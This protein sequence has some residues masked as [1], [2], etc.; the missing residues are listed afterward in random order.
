MVSKLAKNKQSNRTEHFNHL[1]EQKEIEL[2]TIVNKNKITVQ[3]NGNI[4]IGSSYI[5]KT[6]LQPGDKIEITLGLK[7]I[8]LKQVEND[9]INENYLTN[10]SYEIHRITIQNFR[11]IA[12]FTCNFPNKLNIIVKQSKNKQNIYSNNTNFID[13]LIIGIDTF[14]IGFDQIEPIHFSN[15]D[16]LYYNNGNC[17]TSNYPVIIGCKG[18]IDNRE[19]EWKRSL[20]KSGVTNS[21]NAKKLIFLTKDMQHKV[22]QGEPILLPLIACY[23]NHS[24]WKIKQYKTIEP[25]RPESRTMS[26]KNWHNA[27]SSYQK[28][29]QWFQIMELISR[30]RN[31][32]LNIFYAFKQALFKLLNFLEFDNIFYD[33]E[34]DSLLLEKNHDIFS[35]KQIEQYQLYCLSVFFDIAY[36]IAVLNPQLE[37]EIIEKTPG[38]V[39]I[40]GMELYLNSSLQLK[41]IDLLN[42]TFPKL[43]FIITTHSSY[44]NKNLEEQWQNKHLIYIN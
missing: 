44:I 19:I 17:F 1:P 7:Y 30:Q 12:I 27:P 23:R 14:F 29:L 9:N 39:I 31:K 11:E 38:I 18:I 26:Y 35:L 28:I 37:K 10:K 5:S 15:Q 24:I 4:V 8:H 41:F 22:R 2:D 32:P 3:K 21:R 42:L 33:F 25:E 36:R 6:G 40:E 34:K 13:A 43:Q 20:K 16:V